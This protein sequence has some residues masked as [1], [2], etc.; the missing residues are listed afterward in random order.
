MTFHNDIII[1][2]DSLFR[3]LQSV[4]NAAARVI[5]GTR[6]RDHITPVLR[7]LDWLP[8]RHRVDYKLALLVCKSLHGLALSYLP[9]NCILASSD[10]FCHRLSSADVDTCIALRTR[11]R[12]GERSFPAARSGTACHRNCDGQILS[13]ANSVDYWRHFCLLRD[14]WDGGALLTL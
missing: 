13:L 3:R 7:D 9:D 11:T 5:M 12:F 8:V 6:R 4:Q 1:H 10:K 2:I 14:S